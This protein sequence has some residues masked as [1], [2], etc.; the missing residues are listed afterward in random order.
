MEIQEI[1]QRLTLAM[2]LQHYGLKA[3][4]QNRL[5]CPFHND[6]TPSLQLY[7]KTQTAYCFST[8]CNTHGKAIDVI[9]FIMYYEKCSK[10][11]AI[12]KAES[13][14]NP[15]TQAPPISKQANEKAMFLERMFTYFKNAVHNSKPAREY[16]ESRNLD[17]KQLEIGYN[18]GQFH[19]G[20]RKDE[21][22][23]NDCLKYGI[24]LDLGLKSRTGETA[25]KP[26][27]KWCIVFALRNPN[28]EIT[29]LYFRSTLSDKEQRH[30]YLRDRS[31]LYPSYPKADTQKLILTESIIDAASLLQ[32]E[33]IKSKYEIVSLYGTNGLTEEHQTAIRKLKHLTEIIF[34][35]NGDEPG[36][37]AVAKY[38][39]MLKAEYPNLKITSA[40]VPENEDVNSLLQGHS[41]EILTHLIETRK[42]VDFILS[43]E[44]SPKGTEITQLLSDEKEKSEQPKAP[45]NGLDTTNPYNLKYKGNEAAYQIKGFRTDQPDSLKITIQTI[46]EASSITLKLDLYEYKQVESSCKLI[47]GKLGLRKD[48]I[49]A[50]LMQL[51]S[52]LEQYRDKQQFKANGRQESKIQVPAATATKCIG[53]LKAEKLVQRINK[54]IGKAGITGEETNRILLFVIA[55]SYKM[56]DTLHALIQGSSGS[57]KTRLLKII[58]YLMPDE[59]VK[60]YT[61]VT[62]NSF[63]NQ[64]EY[65]FV[66]KLICFEDLDGLKEDAQLA[67]REL[68]SNDILRTSTSIK[69]ASGKISGGERTV[70][71][72]IASLAC[73]TKGEIYEDNISRSFLIAVD[74]SKEQT[75]RVIHYQNHLAAGLVDKEEQKRVTTFVQ[76]C[77]RLLKP[78]EVINPYANKIQLPE[79]AHKIRRLNELYQSFVKQITLLNQYQRKQDKQGRL[80]TE[81]E[82]LQTACEILFE[83]IVLKVDELDGS[84]RQF[85]E[86]LK[87]HLKDKEQEFTQREIRQ[88]LNISKAQCSRFFNHLQ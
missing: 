56:P 2:L 22:L 58:S 31:G 88:M 79:S 54:L 49:E 47:A 7:Y 74:E 12:K 15:T 8:N 63:Y 6:K 33:E 83:S 52:L 9:D 87:S 66:N 69:D 35:L 19:H 44:E 84:L 36:N 18:A 25:Y 62:D 26:F 13:I 70:R 24:L 14:I 5:K 50:D 48:A 27:G 61:R 37:K 57:G 4:K 3:D 32:Q 42:E 10:H 1:K 53:F 76:N 60:R 20:A 75:L 34:F 30:F 40:A 81:T 77:I 39:P 43:S 11:E 64:D 41:P 72:P 38:G 73:T 78:Y 21:S 17:H 71:G 82:D 65:F 29:G 80:I 85:F 68:Q 59:D 67:V 16:I 46:A 51:T 55:S 86:R 23:I 45:I 28:H